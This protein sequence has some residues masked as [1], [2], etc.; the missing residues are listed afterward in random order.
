MA[1]LYLMYAEAY[2][3]YHGPGQPVYDALNL[4][5]TLSGLRDIEDVWSDAS[6]VRNG[7]ALDERRLA[8]YYPHRTFHR[9]EL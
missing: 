5:R 9:A 2:N 1:D 8:R 3:E 6:V 7:Q 4:V